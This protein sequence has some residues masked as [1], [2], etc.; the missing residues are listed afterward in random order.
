MDTW[1]LLRLV[2]ALKCY[3]SY[4]PSTILW[5]A[6]YTV[7]K[8]SMIHIIIHILF[9][10]IPIYDRPLFFPS[11]ILILLGSLFNSKDRACCLGK[12]SSRVLTRISS[13]STGEE[14]DSL[15]QLRF[16][17]DKQY[18]LICSVLHQGFRIGNWA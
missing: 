12:G 5:A 3:S 9:S 10:I 6:E 8:V 17:M 16:F 1:N 18:F 11:K 2:S 15:Q 13:H 14:C 4:H 7:L